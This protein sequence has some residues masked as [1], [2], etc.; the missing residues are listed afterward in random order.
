MGNIKFNEKQF[1][2]AKKR[3]NQFFLKNPDLIENLIIPESHL[4]RLIIAKNF[5]FYGNYQK[6]AFFEVLRELKKTKK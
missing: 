6:P 4:T 5:G 2:L 1:E 3:A